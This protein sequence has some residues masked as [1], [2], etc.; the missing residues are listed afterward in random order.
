[1]LKYLL[2]LD[3]YGMPM[4]LNLGGRGS[5]NTI[6]GVVLTIIHILIIGSYG[7]NRVLQ[8]YGHLD[9]STASNELYHDL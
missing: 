9:P 4:N 2:G 8:L 3:Q 6:C 5:H 7:A 1:M